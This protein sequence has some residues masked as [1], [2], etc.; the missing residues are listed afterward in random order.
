MRRRRIPLTQ[1]SDTRGRLDVAAYKIAERVLLNL[2]NRGARGLR[3]HLLPVIE[4]AITD[5]LP[6]HNLM[7][8]IPPELQAI[9]YACMENRRIL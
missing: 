8:E 5:T 2:E 3:Q 9:F 4:G 1:V 7:D 6:G